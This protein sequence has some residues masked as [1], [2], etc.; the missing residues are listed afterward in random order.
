VYVHMCMQVWRLEDTV[1]V[2]G[3]CELPNLG[4]GI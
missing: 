1:R 4:A 3:I 2:G